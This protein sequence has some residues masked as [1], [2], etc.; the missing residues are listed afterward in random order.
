MRYWEHTTEISKSS[1]HQCGV[2]NLSGIIVPVID[3]R[4]FFDMPY[5]E[6]SNTTV[7]IVLKIMH[8]GNQRVVLMVVDAV[9]DVQS[10]RSDEI[11]ASPDYGSVVCTDYISGSTDI[12][13]QMLVLLDV[14][15]ILKPGSIC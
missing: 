15:Q 9:S 12:G 3:L 2:L 7:V 8:E 4:L 5:I 6:Y 10:L 13:K 14:V 1:P 11:K